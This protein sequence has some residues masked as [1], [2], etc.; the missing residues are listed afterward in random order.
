MEQKTFNFNCTIRICSFIAKMYCVEALCALGKVNEAMDL[1][2][3]QPIGIQDISI[4]SYWLNSQFDN[5]PPG[6]RIKI[7]S[8]VNRA[9]V[10][11]VMGNI[12][13]AC[14]ILRH[15]LTVAPKFSPCVNCL[16]YVL[17]RMGNIQ[18]ALSLTQAYGKCSSNV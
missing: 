3:I 16:I 11:C 4:E 13:D 15:V 5:C 17:L 6:E 14:V 18:E 8:S 2:D 10:Q 9:V 7:I 1:L 12:N